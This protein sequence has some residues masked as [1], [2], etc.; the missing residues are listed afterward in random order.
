MW[1]TGDRPYGHIGRNVRTGSDP[2]RPDAGSTSVIRGFPC[3]AG[4]SALVIWSFGDV[5]R[6]SGGCAPTG[7]R[8][9][10]HF[11]NCGDLRSACP[12]TGESRAVVRNPRSRN[13]PPAERPPDLYAALRPLVGLPIARQQTPA[14]DRA[15]I[16][17]GPAADLG[18]VVGAK[19]ASLR[20]MGTTSPRS[21]DQ[22]GP[23]PF[24]ARPPR[25]T[26]PICVP[27]RDL[28]VVIGD[29]RGVAPAN[30][31]LDPRAFWNA[32]PSRHPT[33]GQVI[34]HF[35]SSR[36]DPCDVAPTRRHARSTSEPA[37][38]RASTE[39]PDI[40]GSD[41]LLCRIAPPRPRSEPTIGEIAQSAQAG[42]N[43]FV[44]A[45]PAV[46]VPCRRWC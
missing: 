37:L 32:R 14:T 35:G 25:A 36:G 27:A 16:R 11:G 40:A 21:A 18:V 12:P 26:G 17:P 38:T 44:P 29:K 6:I 4:P 15:A 1:R 31:Y 13:V 42:I 20:R 28:G 30:G 22:S 34:P 3:P 45:P 33:S 5:L 23:W 24:S 7:A 41:A 19:A 39:T 10:I 9:G 8:C 43:L 46:R 2:G